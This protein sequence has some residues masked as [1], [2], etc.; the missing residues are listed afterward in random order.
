MRSMTWVALCLTVTACAGRRASG[1]PLGLTAQQCGVDRVPEQ[2]V[3]WNEVSASGFTFC[4]P[5]TWTALD[6]QGRHWRSPDAEFSWGDR[7][8]H[9]DRRLPFGSR[10]IGAP[11]RLDQPISEAHPDTKL[12]LSETIDG[13]TVRLT[14][15][16]PA[17]RYTR[18]A[19]ELLEPV[20]HVTGAARTAEAV[21]EII[22]SY[23]S[24]RFIRK[25]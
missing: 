18:A 11:D 13:Q 10:R 1:P 21:G 20:L 2:Y 9:T 8:P 15:E 17:G 12:I 25:S 16:H 24:I 6:A 4:V 7:L 22:A 3:P 23:R 14:L 19:T 5:S